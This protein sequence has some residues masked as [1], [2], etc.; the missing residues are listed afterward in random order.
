MPTVEENKVLQLVHLFR[1]F[2]YML[3]L[4]RRES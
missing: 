2:L 3:H 4:A 1:Q